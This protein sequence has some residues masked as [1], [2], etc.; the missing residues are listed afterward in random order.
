MVILRFGRALRP[1]AVLSLAAGAARAQDRVLEVVSTDSQPVSYAFVQANGGHAQLTDETGHVSMG[2]GKKQTF[3]V[4]VRRIGFTPYFGKID[5][6][7]TAITV[8]IV[9]AP[10][11]QQLSSMRVTSRKSSSSLELNGFYKRWLDMQKGA[12]TAIFIGPEEIEKR[13]ASR[14]SMLLG[15]VN[16]V[17]T[18]R[19]SNGNTVLTTGGGGSCPMAVIVDGRQVCPI[20]GCTMVDYS[21]GLT[22]KNSVLI[23]QVLDINSVAGVEVYKRGGNMP[24]AFHVDSECGAIA[25]WTGSRK[26]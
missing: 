3:D 8:H 23:D 2:R 11:A 25:L 10:L 9:L 26:P 18:T 6:P 13:N 17:S 7:D 1:L 19:T 21:K 15:G 4:E 20:A 12:N 16:G 14:V 24:S 5:L 22:D